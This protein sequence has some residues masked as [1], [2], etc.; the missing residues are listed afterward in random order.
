ML[1]N[2]SGLAGLTGTSGSMLSVLHIAG[3]K[4]EDD[5]YIPGEDAL[6]RNCTKEE[7]QLALDIYCYR[8]K[9]YIGAYTAVLGGVDVVAFSGRI[10]FG[11][12]VIRDKILDGLSYLDFKTEI[13]N[14]DE[15]LAIA[16]KL[17]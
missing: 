9:K 3:E 6:E 11:S 12:S 14:P 16:Q 2:Y 4:T 10:G 15:E 5:S 7:A 13:V 8:I 17:I 1:E